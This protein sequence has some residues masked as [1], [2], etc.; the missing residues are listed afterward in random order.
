MCSSHRLLNFPSRL[1]P[2][3]HDQTASRKP[4][5]VPKYCFYHFLA[6]G[7][8]HGFQETEYVGR[9]SCERPT[10]VLKGSLSDL[11]GSDSRNDEIAFHELALYINYTP[12]DLHIR[13]DEG[14]PF[15]AIHCV[16]HLR[17]PQSMP[18]LAK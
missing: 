9:W 3:I 4:A 17:Y 16:H 12:V 5:N 8:V 1:Q 10:T 6:F 11:D 18:Q 14:L 7:L 13:A 15:Y 2:R